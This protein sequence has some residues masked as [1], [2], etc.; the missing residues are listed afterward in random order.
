[1]KIRITLLALL[2]AG[3]LVPAE[4]PATAAEKIAT[5]T[6]LAGTWKGPM[7]GGTFTTQYSSPEGGMVLSTNKLISDGKLKM[8][9]FEVFAVRGADVL[10]TPFPGGKPAATF[11]MTSLDTKA[12]KAVFEFADKDFPTRITYHR[13]AEKKLVI[14]LDDPH[15]GS[16]EKAVFVL[17]AVE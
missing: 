2:L 10:L 5:M 14:T 3:S 7:W 12:Q 11:K 15:G 4:E 13:T 9:E 8:F 1:M 16:D 6:W 17:S